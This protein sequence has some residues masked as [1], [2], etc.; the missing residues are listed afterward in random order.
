MWTKRHKV[1]PSVVNSLNYYI[2]MFMLRTHWERK[3][4]WARRNKPDHSGWMDGWMDGCKKQ[5]HTHTG[6]SKESREESETYRVLCWTVDTWWWATEWL[7]CSILAWWRLSPRCSPS[8]CSCCCRSRSC[9]SCFCGN[10]Q[11]QQRW[12][13]WWWQGTREKQPIEEAEE[14]KFRLPIVVEEEGIPPLGITRANYL[15]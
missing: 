15:A 5:E 12:W 11:K 9:R 14:S 13:W 10:C 4:V 3:R 6:K 7:Y 8:W 2:K 1:N